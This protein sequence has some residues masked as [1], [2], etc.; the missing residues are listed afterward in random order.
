MAFAKVFKSNL[1]LCHN[2]D[3]ENVAEHFGFHSDW[4]IHNI[5]FVALSK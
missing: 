1:T 4:T 2:L 3:K 5:P